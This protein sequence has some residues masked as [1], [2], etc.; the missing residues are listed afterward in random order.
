MW[1]RKYSSTRNE[2]FENVKK[3]IVLIAEFSVQGKFK[4]INKINFSPLLRSKVAFL[5]SNK[6]SY[7]IYIQVTQLNFFLI[8]TKLILHYHSMRKVMN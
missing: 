2:A 1:R 7:S 3:S 8:N 6:H 5:Y 4:E